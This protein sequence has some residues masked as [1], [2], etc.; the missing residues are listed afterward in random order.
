MAAWVG[1]TAAT[2]A[3]NA[4]QDVL[5][6]RQGALGSLL[7]TPPPVEQPVAK[8]CPK[9]KGKKGKGKGKKASTSKAGKKGKG[10]KKKCGKRKGKG[11][12]KGH[13]KG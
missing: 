2:G 6:W 8:K 13:K 12:K 9:P 7:P 5:S 4:V 1:F 10:K 11:K 3:H